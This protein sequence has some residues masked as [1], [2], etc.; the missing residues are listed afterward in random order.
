MNSVNLLGLNLK[1]ITSFK[2]QIILNVYQNKICDTN[3]NFQVNSSVFYSI[4]LV[5]PY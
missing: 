3:S 2:G 1:L 4:K 5:L